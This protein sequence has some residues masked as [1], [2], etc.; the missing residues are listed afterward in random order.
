[1]AAVLVVASA[2]AGAPRAVQNRVQVFARFACACATLDVSA[3]PSIEAARPRARDSTSMNNQDRTAEALRTFEPESGP[4]EFVLIDGDLDSFA[5]ESESVAKSFTPETSTGG[6]EEFPAELP[7]S[8]SVPTAATPTPAHAVPAKADSAF[9]PGLKAAAV[10]VLIVTPLAGGWWGAR[11]WSRPSTSA[12]IVVAAPRPAAAPQ[13]RAEPPA[14]APA[15]PTS[16]PMTFQVG[17]LLVEAEDAAS[18]QV[19][20]QAPPAASPATPRAVPLEPR[21]S[22]RSI[23]D[24][25]K[26]TQLGTSGGAV[27]EAPVPSRPRT[28]IDRLVA[29]EVGVASPAMANTLPRVASPEAPPALRAV[30]V[31]PAMPA[32]PPPASTL[33]PAR[34][35]PEASVAPAVVRSE[36][37]EIQRALGQYRTAYQRLDAQAART[38]WPT[39][40][41]SALARAFDGLANQELSFDSCRFDIA[42][43]SATAHCSGTATYTRKVGGRGPRSEARHWVFQ[44]RKAAEGWTIQNVQARRD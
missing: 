37:N 12:A 16:E 29:P 39:V 14:V 26:T 15:D 23:A 44:L 7:L 20:S 1:M 38:V 34:P 33:V 32:V 28:D 13:T 35:E 5:S 17:R 40:D 3:P 6:L 41:A 21:A 22:E 43:E 30:E 42:G 36:Q 18:P 8:T 19:L 25:A 4:A 11:L 2:L 24:A 27:L 10:V 31:Q 9:A